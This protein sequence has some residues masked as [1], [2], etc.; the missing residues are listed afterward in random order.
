MYVVKAIKL[1]DR[2][3]KMNKSFKAD[4]YVQATGAYGHGCYRAYDTRT[5]KSGHVN[6]YGY[7]VP[8]KEKKKSCDYSEDNYKQTVINSF[9]TGGYASSNDVSSKTTD[10]A[11][12]TSKE[13]QKGDFLSGI[14]TIGIGVGIVAFIYYLLRNPK[15]EENKTRS[16]ILC[17]FGIVVTI[18]M[19][20]GAN[21]FRMLLLWLDKPYVMAISTFVYIFNVM[22][23]ISIVGFIRLMV[24]KTFFIRIKY[25]KIWNSITKKILKWIIIIFCVVKISPIILMRLDEF[26]AIW[27][28]TYNCQL[29]LVQIILLFILMIF[30]SLVPA[31][32]VG[33]IITRI[34]RLHN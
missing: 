27:I 12:N 25:K 14:A 17:F 2:E 34:L 5:G 4:K 23:V 10:K 6:S 28:D 26:S 16:I 30:V 15:D 18:L 33:Y 13:V 11:D 31:F 29:S 20:F 19:M 22:C 9:S 21:V 32:L 24:G 3:S 8:D 1:L 7:F